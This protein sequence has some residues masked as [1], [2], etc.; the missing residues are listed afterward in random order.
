MRRRLWLGHFAVVLL[1]TSAVARTIIDGTITQLQCVA[2]AEDRT[3]NSV[4]IEILT[5]LED[6]VQDLASVTSAGGK[7]V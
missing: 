1:S 5:R 3:G 6:H 4:W 2:E 7:G